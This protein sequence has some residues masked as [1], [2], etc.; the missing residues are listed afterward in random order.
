MTERAKTGNTVSIAVYQDASLPA[1]KTFT[2]IPWFPGMTILQAMVLA[3]AMYVGSFEFQ[4]EY[5]S[6]YGAFVNQ[7]D[8]TADKGTF[9]WLVQQNHVVA[10]VGVSE[11]I[12]FE[13]HPG[14]NVEIEWI[15]TDTSDSAGNPQVSRKLQAREVRNR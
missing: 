9:Y 5:N 14:Q 7:I 3:Q 10:R 4:V 8:S 2:N 13:G 1:T 12:I 11:A 6:M 15:Y